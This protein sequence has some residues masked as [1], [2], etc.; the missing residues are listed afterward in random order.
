VPEEERREQKASSF[1]RIRG[2][3]A[4]CCSKTESQ[5]LMEKAAV[6]SSCTSIDVI[7]E[8]AVAL[9]GAVEG[10]ATMWGE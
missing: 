2:I 7:F 10:V 9:I 3:M 4:Q 8:V 1:C 6:R 5:V